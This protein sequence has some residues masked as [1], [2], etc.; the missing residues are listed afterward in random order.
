[1]DKTLKNE[2]PTSARHN[3][4]VDHKDEAA[5]LLAQIDV[6]DERIQRNQIETKQLRAETREMLAEIRAGIK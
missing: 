3:Q 6:I 1:M 5:K 2:T 4:T